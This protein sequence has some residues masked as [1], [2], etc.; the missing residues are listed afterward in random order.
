MDASSHTC[1]SQAGQTVVCLCGHSKC[2]LLLAQA[3]PRMIQHPS[4]LHKYNIQCASRFF[5]REMWFNDCSRI[6]LCT[7]VVCTMHK[8]LTLTN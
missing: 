5:L 8:F 3:R 7:H 4:S 2:N 1:S 6:V